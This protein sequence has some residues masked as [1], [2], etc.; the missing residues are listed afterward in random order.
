M[1]SKFGK[2]G[3]QYRRTLAVTTAGVLALSVAACDQN[4]ST[5][6]VGQDIDRTVDKTG[7]QVSQAVDIAEQKMA[8]AKSAVVEGANKV[9]T[10]VGDAAITAKVKSALLTEKGLPSNGIDV[11]TEQGVVSL[12][13]TTTSD[14]SRQ[15]ATQ[16]AAAVEGVKA[17][18]NNLAVVQGS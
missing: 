11:I 4:V 10:A 1:N 14:A 17:V 13:G 16:L 3:K 18:E 7:Q 15:Q 9:G 12:F 5:E 8:D 6:K 2:I